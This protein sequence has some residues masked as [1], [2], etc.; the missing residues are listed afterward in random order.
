MVANGGSVCRPGREAKGSLGNFESLTVKGGILRSFSLNIYKAFL[1]SAFLLYGAVSL[2]GCFRPE[3]SLAGRTDD[4]ES[5]VPS[6]TVVPPTVNIDARTERSIQRYGE[7]V[8]KYSFKYDLDWRLVMA[9]MRHE[10]RFSADAI[11]HRGAFGLMQIMPATQ[12]ELAGKLGVSETE[13]PSNNIIAGI[14]HLQQLYRAIGGT[15]EENHIR[16][17]LAAYNSGLNRVLDAQDVAEYLGYNPQNWQAVKSVL[18]LLTRRYQN[19]HK[20]IWSSG[21]PRAGYFSDWNQT[22]LYV[23]SVMSYYSQYQIA[24]K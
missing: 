18:P 24:L 10:S 6:S 13:S 15:D 9:V 17:T 21:K 11:S 23:E 2:V 7:T 22:Q 8:R 5:I 19:L 1:L 14:F 3:S 4:H 20:N 12:A 16:L